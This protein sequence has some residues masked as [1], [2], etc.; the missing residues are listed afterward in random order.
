MLQGKRAVVTG[1]SSGF[2]AELARLLAAEGVD[3]V[4]S[5]RRK[6]ALD[7]VAADCANVRVEVI[8]A[9]LGTPGGAQ[10]LWEAA[11]AG[12][13][14]D[15]LINNAGFG[16]VRAFVDADLERDAELLQLNITSLVEL[17]RRFLE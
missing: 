4:L 16:Y 17:S 8:T 2:G 5:A 1:A 15:I 12:G 11:S 3:L 9:D 14:I 10:A 6:D 7:K 13:P